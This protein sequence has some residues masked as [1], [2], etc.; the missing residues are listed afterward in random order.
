MNSECDIAGSI[1]D[2]FLLHK[3]AKDCKLNDSS[4]SDLS[5]PTTKEKIDNLEEAFR[6][7][8]ID[9]FTYEGAHPLR[10]PVELA[11]G[12]Y[13]GHTCAQTLLV[14]M[15]SA[16]GYIPYVLNSHFIAA[17]SSEVPM[18]YKVN[19]LADSYDEVSREVKVYQLGRLR[20]VCT[21]SLLRQG[22]QKARAKKAVVQPSFLDL[23][24]RHPDRNNLKVFKHTDYIRTAVGREFFDPHLAPE[25]KQQPPT[26]RWMT[27]FGG[28]SLL[29]AFKDRKF[30]IVGLAVLSDSVIMTTLARILHLPWNPTEENKLTEYEPTR[31]A[32]SLMDV[33]VNMMHI[34]HYNAMSLDHSI[35][36]HVDDFDAI[37]I[38]NEWLTLK[39]QLRHLGNNRALVRGYFY[40]D[41]GHHVAT[42]VQEGLVH[43]S[44]GVAEQVSL[45]RL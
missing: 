24:V 2:L 33:S 11:R 42:I 12:V 22:S 23:A 36:F 4:N 35:Y 43:F 21:V 45:P 39:Y 31:D 14:A 25:E 10:L 41:K 18:T 16:P 3:Y 34:Y 38:C 5:M 44:N 19:S 17:G 6:V 28:I 1:K 26:E 7:K 37:D 40:N 30:N 20:Y 15:E 8:K 29:E 27:V 9:D 32:L 13:G